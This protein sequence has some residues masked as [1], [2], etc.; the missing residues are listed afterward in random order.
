MVAAPRLAFGYVIMLEYISQYHEKKVN[1][2]NV[3]EF[4]IERAK[5]DVRLFEEIYHG[6]ACQEWINQI[7]TCEAEGI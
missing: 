7:L 4:Q 5:S 6:T 2:T 3:V 1:N